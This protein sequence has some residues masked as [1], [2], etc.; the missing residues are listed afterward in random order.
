MSWFVAFGGADDH[1]LLPMPLPL[2]ATRFGARFSI[3][4]CLRDANTWLRLAWS[5]DIGR[6]QVN[7]REANPGLLL[8]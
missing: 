3:S 4:V 7:L 6:R 1:H 2:P 8:H 5:L